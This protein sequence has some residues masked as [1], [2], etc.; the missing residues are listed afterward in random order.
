M[1][2]RAFGE[3]ELAIL[4]ILKSGERKS[5]SDVHKALGGEDKYTSILTVLN[6]L[7]LKKQLHSER[8]GMK[9]SYWIQESKTQIPSFLDQF[10]KKIF[11]VKTT[12]LVSY[13]IN[14]AEDLSDEDLNEMQTMIETAKAQRKK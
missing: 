10:K 2:K 9:N 3:L 4:Q 5:V 6:R 12:S 14:S 13:L 7:V 1:S 8:E 11:G